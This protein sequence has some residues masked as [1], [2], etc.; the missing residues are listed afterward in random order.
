MLEQTR[1]DLRS[2]L[3]DFVLPIVVTVLLLVM[4]LWLCGSLL[5]QPT[6]ST[7]SPRAFGSRSWRENGLSPL[8]L[9]LS[10]NSLW[11]VRLA[12]DA[13]LYYWNGTTWVT[14][15]GRGGSS[16]AQDISITDLGDY[17]AGTDVEAAL[18]ETGSTL[19]GFGTDIGV[20]QTSVDTIVTDPRW[21]DARTPL[22]HVHTTADTIS[23][24]FDD[25]RISSSSVVQHETSLEAVLDL[26]DLQ[27]A[28]TDAQVPDTITKTGT[29][30]RCAR[31]DASGVLVAS[32]GDC[33][34][35]DTTGSTSPGGSTTQV[36]FNDSGVFGGDSDFLWNKTNNDLSLASDTH[37]LLGSSIGLEVQSVSG[38]SVLEAT[39]ASTGTSSFHASNLIATGAIYLDMKGAGAD[40][41]DGWNWAV[42]TSGIFSGSTWKVNWTNTTE[43][44]GTVDTSVSRSAAAVVKLTDA[45]ALTP[46][47]SPPIT[48]G[49]A[50]S[51]GTIYTDTSHALCYCGNGTWTN[52]TPL[53]GGSCS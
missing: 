35:G 19:T 26:S 30:S 41:G 11:D 7:I 6:S 27:G 2:F 12:S 46:R 10:G 24:T 49:G 15:T 32:S 37:I 3:L 53:D 16:N 39:N 28:V 42:G 4:M 8:S 20:L 13:Q 34:S 43:G 18:Q 38:G 33:V 9:P 14:I 45:L 52:L 47:T 25:A 21:T 17:F 22:S 1:R 48:C 5:S 23:G 29:A 36:Q 44:D 40:T 31:F 50:G 51:E